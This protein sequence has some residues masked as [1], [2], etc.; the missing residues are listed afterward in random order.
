MLL[1]GSFATIALILAV[2]GVYAMVAYA[3]NQRMQELA[4]RVALGARPVE[5]VRT[6]MV[7]G[8]GAVGVGLGAGV[9]LA[10]AL[11]RPISVLLY[12]VSAHDPL[13]Y[14]AA[15]AILGLVAMASALIPAVRA[16]RVD[17][18]VALRDA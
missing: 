1:L 14:L 12:G 4:V 10:F 7:R 17:P 8:V 5:V 15:P 6:V 11:G 18:I 3:V 2:G 16:S 9:G 13:I